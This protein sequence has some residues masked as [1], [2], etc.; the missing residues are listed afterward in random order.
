MHQMSPEFVRMLT[1]DADNVEMRRFARL[2]YG[3]ESS[4]WWFRSYDRDDGGGWRE[5][6]GALRQAWS[7]GRSRLAAGLRARSRTLPQPLPHVRAAGLVSMLPV[8]LAD[9]DAAG[10]EESREAH[11]HDFPF[12]G[13]QQACAQAA[14]LCAGDVRW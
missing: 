10:D 7:A 1:A 12:R 2:E 9:A 14:V 8:V 13:R 6:A 5:L 11:G 4:A 3:G